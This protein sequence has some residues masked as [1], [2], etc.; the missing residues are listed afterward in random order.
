MLRLVFLKEPDS[1]LAKDGVRD[2][3]CCRCRRRIA[4]SGVGILCM[5][6]VSLNS[7][8]AE[9]LGVERGR[10]GRVSSGFSLK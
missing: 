9:G 5:D 8:A 1:R 10:E 4:C 3:H 2:L 6:A 7:R